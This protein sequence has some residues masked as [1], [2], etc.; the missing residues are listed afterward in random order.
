MQFSAGVPLGGQGDRRA[1][2]P[3]AS[4]LQPAALDLLNPAAGETLGNRAWLLAIRAGATWRRW[5][6]LAFDGLPADAVGHVG[7][8]TPWFLAGHRIARSCAS[9]VR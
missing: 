5:R 8:F 9:R 3:H 2:P 4:A 7:D 1:Q 6:C